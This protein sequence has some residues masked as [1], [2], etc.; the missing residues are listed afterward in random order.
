ML[1]F[2]LLLEARVCSLPSVCE[3]VCESVRCVE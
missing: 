1:Y 2:V 3:G